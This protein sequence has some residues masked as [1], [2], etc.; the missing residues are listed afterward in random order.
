MNLTV[1]KGRVFTLTYSRWH[2]KSILYL[3]TSCACATATVLLTLCTQLVCIIS[4][5]QTH[6]ASNP[7]PKFQE[8]YRTHINWK[9]NMF[10]IYEFT[11]KDFLASRN[12]VYI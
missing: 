6:L 10:D 7:K 2:T 1:A 9:F 12:N 8:A 5:N 3:D 4:L 11:A